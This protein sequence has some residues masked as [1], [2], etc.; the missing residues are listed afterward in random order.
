MSVTIGGY[1]FDDPE[2]L[3]G[4]DPPYRAGIYAIWAVA[5]PAAISLLSRDYR[6]LYIGQSANM[7]DRVSSNREHRPCWEALTGPDEGLYVATRLTPETS[8]M[9]RGVLERGLI[10]RLAPPCNEP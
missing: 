2:P 7:S 3:D 8:V 1:E 9:Y 4:W 5:L 10:R 6:V